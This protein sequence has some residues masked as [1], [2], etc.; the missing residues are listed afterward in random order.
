MVDQMSHS[1]TPSAVTK[2]QRGRAGRTRRL[3]WRVLVALAALAMAP[4][5]ARGLD[6]LAADTD[7]DGRLDGSIGMAQIAHD[8]AAAVNPQLA[9]HDSDGFGDALERR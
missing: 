4:V 3:A 1:D 8:A 5:A 2:Q 9:D 6:P 7:S